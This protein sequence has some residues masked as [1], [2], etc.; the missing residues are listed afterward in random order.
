MAKTL[1]LI[2]HPGHEIRC[3]GWMS[4]AKPQVQVLTTGGGASKTGRLAST[5]K[6]VE[7]A[8]AK[9]GDELL[10][11]SDH[12][13]YGFMLNQTVQPL[14]E[15]TEGVTQIILKERPTILLTDMVEGYNSSHDLVAY[16]TSIA[17]ERA[18]TLGWHIPQVFCQPLTGASDMAWGGKLAPVITLELTLEEFDQKLSAA[19][20]YPELAEEVENALKENSAVSFKKECLYTTVKGASILTSLPEPKPFYETFGELQVSRGKFK[21]VI[22]HAQHLVPLVKTIRAAAGLSVA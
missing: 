15:W 20:G 16:L 11:F 4:R 5:K 2:G 9:Y 17:V 12:E 10:T 22:R 8:G 14:I 18:A 7:Q 19:R 6:I 1:L 3:H 13:V 21:D